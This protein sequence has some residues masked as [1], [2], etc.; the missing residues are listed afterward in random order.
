MQI[1]LEVYHFKRVE[2]NLNNGNIA[3]VTT[4][5]STSFKYKSSFLEE[6]IATDT[7]AVGDVAA[8][9]ILHNEIIAVPLKYLSKFFRVLEMPLINCKIHL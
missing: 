1:S 5:D 3:D 9:R 7:A 8:H 4:N 6:L 2:Q